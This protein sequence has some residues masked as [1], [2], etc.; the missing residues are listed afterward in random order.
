[1]CECLHITFYIPEANKTGAVH[2]PNKLEC[3]RGKNVAM[4]AYWLLAITVF[5]A[6]LG[7]VWQNW[8]QST[9]TRSYLLPYYDFI[10]GKIWLPSCIY[11]KILKFCMPFISHIS[12]VCSTEA[13]VTEIWGYKFFNFQFWWLKRLHIRIKGFVVL[14]FLNFYQFQ[15]IFW[16]K[17]STFTAYCYKPG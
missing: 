15:I 4:F 9:L 5:F 12:H 14:C 3:W 16:V 2:G 17:P 6:I 13:W 11:C 1:M 10:I 8:P 7:L